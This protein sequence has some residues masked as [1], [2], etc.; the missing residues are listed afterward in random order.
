[1]SVSVI[2]RAA[3]IFTVDEFAHPELV[4]HHEMFDRGAL[5]PL[6]PDREVPILVDHEKDGPVIGRVTSMRTDTCWTGGT[7]LWV[8]A[9]ITDPPPWLR[10]DATGVSIARSAMSRRDMGGWELIRDATLNEVSLLS[11]GVGPAFPRS[12]VT[13]IG[14]PTDSPVARPSS[15]RAAAGEVILGG[16]RIVRRNIGQVLAVG[17]RPL[18]P[19]RRVGRDV[20]V[21]H[22]DGS[23]TM[24]SGPEGSERRFVTA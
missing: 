12:R 13:W 8:H 9:E 22:E 1:V 15:D 16:E 4:R 11:P 6:F 24:Y 2:L 21:D 17:G 3:P 5:K 18:S 10:T 20:I 14:K 7:W 23:S 19:T